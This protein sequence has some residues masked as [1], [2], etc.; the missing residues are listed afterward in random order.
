MKIWFVEPKA[1][2]FISGVK[3][4]VAEKIIEYLYSNCPQN[5][6]LLTFRSISYPPGYQIRTRGATTKEFTTLS[7]LQLV[8]ET[9]KPQNN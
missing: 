9:V 6:G 3:D 5:S 4:T 1:N 2:V 7:G 8:I